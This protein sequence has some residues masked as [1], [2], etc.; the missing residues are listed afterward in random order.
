MVKLKLANQ[1][2]RQ[3]TCQDVVMTTRVLQSVQ[4]HLVIAEIDEKHVEEWI[5]RMHVGEVDAAAL[6][7]V[8]WT[9]IKWN[10]AWT[11]WS[12]VARAEDKEEEENSAMM[13]LTYQD[14]SLR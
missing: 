2:R 7:C 3:W 12:G 6:D 4:K 9:N 11:S 1:T 8:K 14:N 10:R 5:T 13:D